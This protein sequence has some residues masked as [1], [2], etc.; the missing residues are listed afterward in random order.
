MRSPSF[1]S[2]AILAVLVLFAPFAVAVA[3][4]KG[5]D[6]EAISRLPVS[7][8][9][10]VKGALALPSFFWK[11]DL[12][13]N[14]V[15]ETGI[16]VAGWAYS[17]ISLMENIS[18]QIEGGYAG[19]GCRL[20]ASDGL[21][22]WLTHYLEIPAWLKF[23]Y[24]EPDF[25]VYAGAGG[26]FA[27]F[28]GGTYDFNVPGSEWTGSGALIQG[29]DEGATFVRPYDYGLIFTL[30]WETGQTVFEFRLPIAIM[31][32]IEITPQDAT[33]GAYRGALNSGMYL[34]VGYRF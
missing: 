27:W 6:N 23:S 8:D 22:I 17:S 32:S 26:Y 10:G 29:P 1:R 15:T 12:G 9:L 7:I 31:A 2:S 20:D 30:G 21:M 19:K 34:G 16:W 3:Q 11:G 5:T 18:L 4:G 14:S 24:S 13:W 33:Y 25:S 28:L